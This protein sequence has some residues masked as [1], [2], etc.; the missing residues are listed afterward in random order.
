[1][2]VQELHEI[3]T[4]KL[5]TRM[6]RVHSTN[7]VEKRWQLMSARERR[8]EVSSGMWFQGGYL[9]SS[10]WPY[11]HA[12]TESIKWIHWAYTQHMKL[13]GKVVVEGN[14]E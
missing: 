1:M 7:L 8:I 5:P 11:T 12:N 6:G 13:G 9:Y 3:K 10:G 2:H 14:R 4:A